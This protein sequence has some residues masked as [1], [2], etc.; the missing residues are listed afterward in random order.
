MD[1]NRKVTDLLPQG[2]HEVFIQAAI[3]PPQLWSEIF[4]WPLGHVHLFANLRCRG[5]IPLH[6]RIIGTRGRGVL[7]GIIN[8]RP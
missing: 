2:G 7:E 4:V 5:I 1:R 6:R 8:D 3:G